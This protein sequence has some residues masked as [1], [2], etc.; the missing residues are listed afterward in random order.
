MEE[1]AKSCIDSSAAQCLYFATVLVLLVL[2]V[3]YL[4]SLA[5]PKAS[6]HAIGSGLGTA[7]GSLQ[8]AASG[9]RNRHSVEFG[10]TNQENRQTVLTMDVAGATGGRV[11][12]NGYPVDFGLSESEHLVNNRGEP[13]FWTTG[14]ELGAYKRSQAPGMRSDAASEHMTGLDNI[15]LREIDGLFNR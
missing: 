1:F 9:P 6:E 7:S 4:K 12:R 10:G 8:A 15:R 5:E 2:T 11:S 14:S 13:D 3:F